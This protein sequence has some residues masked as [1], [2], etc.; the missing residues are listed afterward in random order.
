MSGPARN[1]L[2][3]AGPIHTQ[4]LHDPPKAPLD[5][6][7]HI[8]ERAGIKRAESSDSRLSKRSRSASDAP[9]ARPSAGAGERR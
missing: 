9:R 8:A 3:E 7:I 4:E 5:L 6:G 2:A 1:E